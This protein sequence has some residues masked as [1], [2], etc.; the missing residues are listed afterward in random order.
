MRNRILAVAAACLATIVCVGPSNTSSADP[1]NAVN[2]A[3]CPGSDRVQCA[4]LAVPLDW[5]DEHGDQITL[6]VA[7][8]PADQPGRRIGTLFYNPGGPGDGGVK[9]LL[10]ADSFFSGVFS[11]ALKARFDIVAMDGAGLSTL[12]AEEPPGFDKRFKTQ[13][14]AP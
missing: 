13:T 6:S 5:A 1:A 4:T 11:A 12:L 9:Y 10:G 2:W 3:L 14:P 8:R 7:R